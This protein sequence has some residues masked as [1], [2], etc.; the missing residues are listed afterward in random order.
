MCSEPL[1]VRTPP[2]RKLLSILA[3]ALL[4]TWAVGATLNF[5]NPTLDG[6]TV[7]Y[8]GLG[9]SLVAA[10]VIFQQV[11]AV[12]TPANPGVSLYCA[13]VPCLLDFT[14]GANL[15]E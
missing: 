12:N 8:D 10:D 2:M 13:P 1:T 9:A 5:D 3:L 6:G 4:P 7:T 14:T 15:N 11:V